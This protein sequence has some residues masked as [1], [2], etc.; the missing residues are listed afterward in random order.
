MSP[1]AP[2]TPAPAAPAISERMLVFLIGAVQFVNILDFVMVMPLGPDFA[3]ALGIPA[4]QVGLIGG[5]YTAAG[6]VSGVVGLYF[7]DRF[8]RRKA[9][10]VS[11]VGLVVGTA[12]GGLATGL[13]SLLAAR[14]VAGLFGGPATSLALAIIADVVPVER[15]GRALGAVMGAFSV[16]S[17]VG[18]PAALKMAEL[19]SWHTPFFVVAGMGLVVVVGAIFAL[20][21]LRVHLEQPRRPQGEV[22]MRDLFMRRDVLLSYSMTAVSMMGGFIVIPNISAFTQ[23]N[24]GFPREDLWLVYFVGGFVSIATLRVAGQLVDRQ[25][26]FRVASVSA[27]MMVASLYLCFLWPTSPVSP[28]LLI[29]L[30]VFFFMAMGTRNVSVSTLASRVP[31]TAIRARFMSMQSA[32][33]HAASAVGAFL[34]ARLLSVL[35]DG[36]LEGMERVVYSSMVLA[37]VL[38]LVMGLVERQVQ[39]RTHPQP[40]P[41]MPAAH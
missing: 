36:R 3:K 11:M 7:L 19:G 12:A 8:D 27:V 21:P 22:G 23:A 5:S 1:Q 17:I 9:L 30:F 2:A 29:G 6:F 26:S 40:A 37:A 28:W 33:Q 32:V 39:Q 31:E 25:G 34:S 10:A 20:P 18:V 14:V 16:A 41:G 35:P 38:P 13:Y 24:L 4:S 15:R